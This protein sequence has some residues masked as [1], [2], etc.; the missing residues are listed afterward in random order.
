MGFLGRLFSMKH[1]CS[2]HLGLYQF[3]TAN[4]HLSLSWKNLEMI[5]VK[6]ILT[7]FEIDELYRCTFFGGIDNSQINIITLTE[8]MER[9]IVY[10]SA[11]SGYFDK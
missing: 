6:A 3:I 10:K 7:I 1:V 8:T 9:T 5:G 2:L 4:D 11:I